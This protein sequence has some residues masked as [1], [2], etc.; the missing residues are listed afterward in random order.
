MSNNALAAV[1]DQI[2]T[3]PVD[4]QALLISR[5]PKDEQETVTEILDE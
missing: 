2:Q 3:L 4:K 5:L 1:L